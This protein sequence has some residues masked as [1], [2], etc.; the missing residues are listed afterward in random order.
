MLRTGKRGVRRLC[1]RG[2]GVMKVLCKT[3]WLKLPSPLAGISVESA[4][5]VDASLD[6]SWLS[7][8][9]EPS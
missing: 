3:G 4:S 8:P 2:R 7:R 5:R 6:T 1:V 9:A